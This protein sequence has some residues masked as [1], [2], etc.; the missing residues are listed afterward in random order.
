MAKKISNFNFMNNIKQ[1]STKNIFFA[2][3]GYKY[4]KKFFDVYNAT[5]DTR[6]EL[7]YNLYMESKTD[8]SLND[9]QKDIISKCYVSYLFAIGKNNIA[10]PLVMYVKNNKPNLT[11]CLTEKRL[12][13]VIDDYYVFLE[14]VGFEF[15]CYYLFDF[16]KNFLKSFGQLQNHRDKED[17]TFELYLIIALS[18][19]IRTL[20]PFAYPQIWFAL[21]LMKNISLLSY[22]NINLL[23]ETV[24]IEVNNLIKLINIIHILELERNGTKLQSKKEKDNAEKSVILPEDELDITKTEFIKEEQ[25]EIENTEKKQLN[26]EVLN[27]ESSY[28]PII[29]NKEDLEKIMSG[30][31]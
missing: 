21:M 13:R 24:I 19:Y 27:P 18:K 4:T 20:S 31:I 7:M 25:E 1:K 5:L 26:E 30:D 23:D 16:L 3:L 6:D 12:K 10:L 14:K 2:P 22:V 15:E 8:T 11:K 28:I 17:A 29:K 9:K